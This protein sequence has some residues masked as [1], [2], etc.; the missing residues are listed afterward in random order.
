M[1]RKENEEKGEMSGITDSIEDKSQHLL[2]KTISIA[3]ASASLAV[4]RTSSA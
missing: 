2:R 4:P 1:D 3:I